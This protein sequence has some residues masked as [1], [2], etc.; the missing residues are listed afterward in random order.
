M[1][2]STKKLTSVVRQLGLGVGLGV[3]AASS[4]M[5]GTMI[6]SF[7]WTQEFEFIDPILPASVNKVAGPVGNVNPGFTKL[8]WGTE[9]NS[10][11]KISSLVINPLAGDNETPSNVILSGS[12]ATAIVVQTGIPVAVADFQLGPKVVHNNF[13]ITGAALDSAFAK[14]FVELTPTGGGSTQ[15][16]QVTFG[17]EFLETDNG[18]RGAAC[19]SGIVN[20]FGCGDIFALTLGFGAPAFVN[21][22]GPAFEIDDFDIDGWNYKVY[23]QEATGA[24]Q[25][26]SQQA[27]LAAGAPIGC[28]GFVTNENESNSFQLQFAIVA[29][30]IPPPPVPVPATLFLMGGSLLSLAWFRRRKAA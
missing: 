14:D 26:L 28:V 20:A 21:S 6:T 19:P 1:K 23:L 12:G 22:A 4:S 3:F 15:I 29:A 7:D 13:V 8:S 5:A 24:I 25:P 16:Q 27:C 30:E 18:L 17:I 11:D 9:S 10:F 2:T